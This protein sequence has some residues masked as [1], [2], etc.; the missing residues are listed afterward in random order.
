MRKSR[1]SKLAVLA[2]AAVLAG[3]VLSSAG[4]AVQKVG[5]ITV[6]FNGGISPRKLPRSGTAPVG[7]Q[8]GGKIRTANSAEPPVLERIVLDINRNGVIQTKGL[9]HCPLGKLKNATQAGA[10]RA[11]GD[12]L[13]GRGSVTSRVSLPDQ[14]AFASNGS[15]LAFNGRYRGHPAVFAQVSSGAPLPLTYVIV[16]QVQKGKGTFGTKLIGTMPQI[17]SSY[18][19]ITAFNLSL[20]RTYR[21]GG[22]RLS[23]ASAGCPAPSGFRS[24]SFPLA[25]VGYEFADGT[26]VSETLVRECRVRG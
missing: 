10:R 23:Y 19:Y 26:N 22:K 3:L 6:T 16:F 2:T 20:R 24:A 15:M 13:V 1:L 12:A 4:Q 21:F 5:D 25:K 14:G 18:G 9:G 8:M 7:V 17:A 11:C